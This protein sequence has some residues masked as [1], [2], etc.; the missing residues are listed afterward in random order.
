V[1]FG[2]DV[3]AG[4]VDATPSAKAPTAVATAVKMIDLRT[5]SAT[6]FHEGLS[7]SRS[8][9]VSWLTGLRA[10]PSQPAERASGVFAARVPDHSGGSAPDLHR[11]P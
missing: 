9:E 8:A 2:P 7:A 5:M 6:P 4:A 11:L 3:A 1:T 10:A